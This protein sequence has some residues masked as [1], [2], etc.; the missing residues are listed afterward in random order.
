MS[1]RTLL[2]IAMIAGLFLLMFALVR[3][4][5]S[6]SRQSRYR[7]QLAQRERATGDRSPMTAGGAGNLGA[8]GLPLVAAA[9]P[10][11]LRPV[12]PTAAFSTPRIRV[13]YPAPQRPSQFVSYLET[14]QAVEKS[15][16]STWGAWWSYLTPPPSPAPIIEGTPGT[17]PSAPSPDTERI[18]PD[19]LAAAAQ[20]DKS[21]SGSAPESSCLAFHIT[22]LHYLALE[23]DYLRRLTIL[24]QTGSPTELAALQREMQEILPSAALRVQA[25]LRELQHDHPELSPNLK[26]IQIQAYQG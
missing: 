4:G 13:G 25:K 19:L 11:P 26:Q 12:A 18:A 6:F 21:L 2:L 15:R 3:W 7:Q 20:W 24:Q 10:V 9:T 22:Y 17:D 5:E 1:T 14:V 16:Q 23:K 8:T